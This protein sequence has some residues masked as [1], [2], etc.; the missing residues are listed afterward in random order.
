MHDMSNI[1]GTM[2]I[3]KEDNIQSEPEDVEVVFDNKRKQSEEDDIQVLL[4]VTKY[5]S[6]GVSPDKHKIDLLKHICSFLGLSCTQI[7][8]DDCILIGS[9]LLAWLN[10]WFSEM[11]QEFL[12]GISESQAVRNCQASLTDLYNSI[13]MGS[14]GDHSIST[15]SNTTCDMNSILSGSMITSQFPYVRCRLAPDSLVSEQQRQNTFERASLSDMLLDNLYRYAENFYLK[16]YHI[17]TFCGASCNCNH[18][19]L[20][21]THVIERIDFIVHPKLFS[22][23]EEEKASFQESKIPINEKLLFHGTHSTNLNKILDDN[24]KLS[25]DPVSR[26]KFNLYGKGIYFSD[27]P[28]HSLK[29]GEALLLCKVILGKEEVIQLGHT[30][31]TTESYF[32]RNYHSRKMVDSLDRK[33]SSAKIY[34]VPAPQQILPCYVIYLKKKSSETFSTTTQK[35]VVNLQ[36]Q[37]KSVSGAQPLLGSHTATQVPN[38]SASLFFSHNY[39]IFYVPSH[40]TVVPIDPHLTEVQQ[41]LNEIKN[42][43]ISNCASFKKKRLSET[44]GLRIQVSSITKLYFFL[45]CL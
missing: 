30:P 36:T 5:S 19:P 10:E 21:E 44:L 9:S 16:R 42:F 45:K 31:K 26:K 22:E 8:D 18:P 7:F 41:K 34:M 39:P 38:S 3:P 15:E 2:N 33:N 25:A 24:F 40:T 1:K 23:Y 20:S 29:Y 14:L 13:S 37:A 17:R 11:D 32:R 28:A 35:S 6:T 43:P 27:F 12:K 4:E